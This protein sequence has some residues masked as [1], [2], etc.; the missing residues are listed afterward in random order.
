MKK[1]V[2][3]TGGT[4]FIGYHLIKRCI[5]LK[6]DVTCISSKPIRK[7]NFFRKVKYKICDLGNLSRLKR[8]IIR[9][10]DFVVNL[11]GNID[12]NN[13]KKTYSSHYL[14]VKN[15]YE[16]LKLKNI[17]KFIQIGSSSEYGKFF[18]KVKETDN[19]D[20]KMIYGRS[21]LKSSNFLIK[22]FKKENFPVLILR[23][24]Q[25]YGPRQKKNRLIPFVIDS[26]LRNINFHC[27]EGSQ[28]R[29]FLYVDDAINAIIKSLNFSVR[30]NGKIIN[31]GYGKPI[32]VKDLILMIQNIIK[33]GKPVFG[34]L[35]LRVDESK[36]IYP[37]LERSKR[38]LN[39]K[40]KISLKEGLKK[41]VKFYNN[42]ISK[43]K[44]V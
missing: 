39:W 13:K 10:Y 38:I 6:M 36:K 7:L 33:K 35:K 30:S 24:F 42:R 37:N 12:H 1:K 20:P 23:F 8:I 27:S 34:K 4:G 9:D 40:H 17:K 21:K 5:E 28:F 2:L 22:K 11:A 26:S 41:T 29:D 18:G 16:V 43:K 19:C 25:V 14:G 31:I 32:K 44:R 3:I 15:L